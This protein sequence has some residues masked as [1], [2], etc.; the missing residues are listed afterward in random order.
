MKMIAR[1][2]LLAPVSVAAVAM[3]ALAAAPA[4]AT[5]ITIHVGSQRIPSG[6]GCVYVTDDI[7]GG[8]A[9][10]IKFTSGGTVTVTGI[11]VNAGDTVFFDYRDSNCDRTTIRQDSYTAPSDVASGVWNI[12]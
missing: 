8:S 6:A 2:R 1:K 7:S 12:N 11:D 10:G 3:V 4:S 5:S 9:G